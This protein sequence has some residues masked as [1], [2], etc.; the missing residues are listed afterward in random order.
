MASLDT[1][2]ASL[3]R[4]LP[5]PPDRD[6]RMVFGR[7]RKVHLSCRHVFHAVFVHHG[8]DLCLV[9]CGYAVGGISLWDLA[10]AAVVVQEEGG[11]PEATTTRYRDGLASGLAIGGGNNNYNDKLSVLRIRPAGTTRAPATIV[12]FM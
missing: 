11:I 2:G 7:E 1:T 4:R 12:I 3:L 9:L 6:L 5:D 10:G 8:A